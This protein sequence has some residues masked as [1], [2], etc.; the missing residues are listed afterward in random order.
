MII[1][2]LD[3]FYILSISFVLSCL[4]MMEAQIKS[5]KTMMEYHIKCDDALKD[6]GKHSLKEKK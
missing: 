1:S 4:F 5:I 6:C 2:I 3:I